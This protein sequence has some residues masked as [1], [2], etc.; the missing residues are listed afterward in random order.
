LTQNGSHKTN[1][2]WR[3]IEIPVSMGLENEDKKLSSKDIK[4]SLILLEVQ[5]R[6]LWKNNMKIMALRCVQCNCAD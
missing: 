6:Q 2:T 1:R 3:H 4:I 5:A